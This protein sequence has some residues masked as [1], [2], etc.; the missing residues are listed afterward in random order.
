MQPTI[1]NGVRQPTREE[2]LLVMTDEERL[3]AQLA[4]VIASTDMSLTPKQCV[5]FAYNCIDEAIE[6]GEKRITKRL[7]AEGRRRRGY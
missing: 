2:V 7:E 1:I 5:E 3:A 6:V 4:A